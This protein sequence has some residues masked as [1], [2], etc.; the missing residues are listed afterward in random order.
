[1]KLISVR[2]GLQNSYA[3]I[4]A[5]LQNPT[6]TI[7]SQ[8]HTEATITKKGSSKVLY[9]ANK[10]HMSIAPNTNFDFPISVNKKKIDPGTYML[11]VD[12]TTENNQKKWHLAKTFT[13]KPENAKKINDE[14]I[15]EEKAEV[16]YLPMIIG[17]GGLLLGIIVFLSY[18]LFQQ[19]GR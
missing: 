19:K 7:I 9:T 11:T 5:H 10:D 13:I 6:S 3:T 18:K 17:I 16:S 4:F 14:A 2:T 12:A 8:V 15:T 1:M